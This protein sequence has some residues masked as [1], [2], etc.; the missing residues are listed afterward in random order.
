MTTPNPIDIRAE[1]IQ[2]EIT[3]A[4]VQSV[5]AEELQFSVA[6]E[7]CFRCSVLEHKLKHE[8][9]LNKHRDVR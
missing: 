2:E 9:D 8:Q 5:S 6:R 3:A 7:A 4:L 1:A